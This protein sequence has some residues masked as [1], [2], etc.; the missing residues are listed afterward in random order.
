MEYLW[1]LRDQWGEPQRDHCFC[2]KAREE[3]WGLPV[4]GEH[5]GMHHTDCCSHMGCHPYEGFA[6]TRGL[7]VGALV[8]HLVAL[9][10]AQIGEASLDTL[11]DHKNDFVVAGKECLGEGRIDLEVGDGNW[12]AVSR[13]SVAGMT[14]DRRSHVHVLLGADSRLDQHQAPCHDCSCHCVESGMTLVSSVDFQAGVGP[15][16]RQSSP[17]IC[18]YEGQLNNPL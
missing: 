11:P 5:S 18:Q 2:A 1:D 8:A 9:G 14:E 15:R 10:Y 12:P 6:W 4:E 3:I 7:A 13:T 17:A 16:I